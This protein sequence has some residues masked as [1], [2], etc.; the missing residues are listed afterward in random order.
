MPIQLILPLHADRPPQAQ[1]AAS[2]S[3]VAI[4]HWYGQPTPGADDFRAAEIERN[5]ALVA[6]QAAGAAFDR[7]DPPLPLLW[8]N[9]AEAAARTKRRGRAIRHEQRRLEV[10]R[11][12]VRRMICLMPP[13]RS[14]LELVS[15]G[16]VYRDRRFPE[17]ETLPVPGARPDD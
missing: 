5:A 17:L 4:P 9:I 12:R 14:A 8:S 6:W 13:P 7:A 3:H 10:A 16:Q 11:E 15:L 2:R 1:A